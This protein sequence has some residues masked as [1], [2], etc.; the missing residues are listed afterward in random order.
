MVGGHDQH[1]AGLDHT[2]ARAQGA[3]RGDARMHAGAN[4]VF[5]PNTRAADANARRHTAGHCG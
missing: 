3:Q 2:G 4:L 1:L 5:G